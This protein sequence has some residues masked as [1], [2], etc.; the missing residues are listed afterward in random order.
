M[1]LGKQHKISFRITGM[2]R[3][4]TQF[5]P[6]LVIILLTAQISLLEINTAGVID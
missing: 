6:E 2:G 5:Q 3:N 4:S 1:D